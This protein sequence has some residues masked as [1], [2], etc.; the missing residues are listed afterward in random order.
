M[1]FC[2]DLHQQGIYFILGGPEHLMDSSYSVSQQWTAVQL[3]SVHN[4]LLGP[5]D[6]CRL[7][8]GHLLGSHKRTSGKS[9]SITELISVVVGPH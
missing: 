6:H 2:S 5:S 4:Q 1:T 8:D 9:L 7:P 3:H